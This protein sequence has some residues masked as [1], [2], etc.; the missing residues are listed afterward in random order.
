MLLLR[1]FSTYRW[2]LLT[3]GLKTHAVRKVLSY[4]IGRFSAVSDANVFMVIKRREW[5]RKDSELSSVGMEVDLD[6]ADL[7]IALTCLKLSQTQS[8]KSEVYCA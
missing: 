6:K 5:E 1:R 4:L 2:L 3:S 8:V 7:S